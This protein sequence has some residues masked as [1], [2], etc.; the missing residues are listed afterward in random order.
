M[1]YEQIVGHSVLDSAV[2]NVEDMREAAAECRRIASTETDAAK[3]NRLVAH[4][5]HL[6]ATAAACE[7]AAPIRSRQDRG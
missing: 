2:M 3:R 7:E 1:G 4:A 6:D 5:D